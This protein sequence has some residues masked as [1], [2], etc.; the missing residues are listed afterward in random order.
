MVAE[1]IIE[2]MLHAAE[3][4]PVPVPKSESYVSIPDAFGDPAG[5]VAMTATMSDPSTGPYHE[6]LQ[7]KASEIMKK[8]RPRPKQKLNMLPKCQGFEKGFLTPEVQL[9]IY[10]HRALRLVYA[11]AAALDKSKAS[12]M[13]EAESWNKHMLCIIDAA[14]A[15]T[16]YQIL[17]NIHESLLTISLE[18]QNLKPVLTR[19]MSLYALSTVINPST[20]AAI[21][22]IEDGCLS[23]SQLNDI[24]E[25]VHD[26][27]GELYFEAIGLTDAWDFSDAS[28][29]SA[30][31]CYD[32]NAYE[33][34][35]SW[36]RQLPI[37][38]KA[39]ENEQVYKKGWEETLKPFLREGRV[40]AIL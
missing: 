11:T 5:F 28:L 37:N 16:E 21:T 30:I 7:E 35:M 24:R 6:W 19:L 36:V 8:L 26:L 29:C 9:A 3:P 14:R 40:K 32:G 31:G 34:M 17:G 27:L 39:K 1:Q 12:G 22:W 20:P 23:H 4:E 18:Y 15:H 38:V 10:R 33:R 2:E 13:T 25:N